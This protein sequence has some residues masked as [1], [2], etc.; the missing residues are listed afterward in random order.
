MKNIIKYYNKILSQRK[1]FKSSNN[2]TKLFNNLVKYNKKI[3]A[4]AF[5]KIWK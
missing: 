5:K 2:K 1:K 3:K 4:L